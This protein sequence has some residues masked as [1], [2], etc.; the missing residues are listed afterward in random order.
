MTSSFLKTSSAR[1]M[2]SDVNLFFTGLIRRNR[3]S[4]LFTGTE[5]FYALCRFL[6]DEQR[7]IAVRANPRYWF[8][9]DNELAFRIAIAGVERFTE[10]GTTLYQLSLL[11]LGTGNRGLI[12]FINLLGMAT[13]RVVATADKHTEAPLT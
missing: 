7:I 6:L 5:Q 9:I 8:E 4:T 3:L 2:E 11:A 12:W 1:A 10:P 13:F